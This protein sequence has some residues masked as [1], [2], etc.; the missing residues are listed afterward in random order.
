MA[1]T[2]LAFE[3]TAIQLDEIHIFMNTFMADFNRTSETTIFQ[4]VDERALNTSANY[5]VWSFE[6]TN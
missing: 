2:I 5:S 6:L 4:G 3:I 1:F